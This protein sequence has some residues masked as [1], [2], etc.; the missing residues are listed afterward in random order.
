M[1]A[2]SEL[3]FNLKGLGW[4]NVF[5]V[6]TNSITNYPKVDGL[7][8]NEIWTTS[9]WLMRRV[10]KCCFYIER[11]ILMCNVRQIINEKDMIVLS[12]KQTLSNYFSYQWDSFRSTFPTNRVIV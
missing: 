7:S 11:P 8:L 5:S 4:Q 2:S 6:F 12:Q 1:W 3:G 10:I 9:F